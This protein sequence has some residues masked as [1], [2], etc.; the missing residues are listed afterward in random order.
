M[1]LINRFNFFVLFSVCT[2]LSL[3]ALGITTKL[4][5]TRTPPSTDVPSKGYPL[6]SRGALPAAFTACLLSVMWGAISAF[7]PLYAVSHGISNPG[8][9][10]TFFA[11]MLIFG[12][13][14]GGKIL[15]IYDRE[16]VAFS[17]LVMVVLSMTL[18]PFSKTLPMFLLVAVILGIGWAFLYPSLFIYSVEHSGSFRG[19]AMATFSGL[20]DLGVGIGPMI[21]GIL[22]EWT[23]YPVMFSC[24]TGISVITLIYFYFAIGRRRRKSTR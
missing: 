9:F 19:P 12:R 5:K 1:L 17:C 8:I 18:L 7:F 10:F 13:V 6:L 20:A 23:S 4:S 2:G 16:K 14:L 24:L 22:L 3:C 11:L 21:M 15:D